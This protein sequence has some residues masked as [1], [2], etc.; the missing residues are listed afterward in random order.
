MCNIG[1]VVNPSRLA[2]IRIAADLNRGRGVVRV[3]TLSIVP[4][5]RPSDSLPRVGPAAEVMHTIL[6]NI[7]EDWCIAPVKCTGVANAVWRL[8]VISSEVLLRMR[9]AAVIVDK[10]RRSVNVPG[11][12]AAGQF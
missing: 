4:R 9:P 8:H 7:I 10:S 6:I 11:A 3:R 1:C 2:A 12:S 5:S